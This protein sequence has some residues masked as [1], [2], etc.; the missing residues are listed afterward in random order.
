[1][2]EEAGYAATY[3]RLAGRS[4]HG[5]RG[6]CQPRSV[7]AKTV[8]QVADHVAE[9][10]RKLNKKPAIIGHSFGGLLVQILAGRGLASATVAI[11]P[12]PFRGVLPLPFSALK[13]AWPV[14]GNPPTAIVPSTH[15]RAVPLRVRQRGRR[16]RGQAALRYLPC[17]GVGRSTL[18]GRHRKPESMDRGERRDRESGSRAAAD[19]LGRERQHRPVGDRQ[20]VLQTGAAQY[21]GDR[22]RRDSE[23]RALAYH[24]Q[25]LAGSRRHG[26]YIYPAIRLA[27]RRSTVWRAALIPAAAF[28][29][30]PATKRSCPSASNVSVQCTRN[31]SAFSAARFFR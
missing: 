27:P 12:A 8:G 18:S 4:G 29:E 26:A 7:R 21:R 17:T 16:G 3:A 14:L 30:S 2:F 6:A 20:R 9:I 11:D 24:R 19:H 10:V 13:A 22:D 25:R 1:M 15:F 5:R 31:C 28:A 23:P